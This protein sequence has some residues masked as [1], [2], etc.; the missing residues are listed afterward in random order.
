M[1]V[2]VILDV[3]VDV[4]TYVFLHG[5]L[6]LFLHV[7]VYM[8]GNVSIHMLLN[9]LRGVIAHLLMEVFAYG[10]ISYVFIYVSPRISSLAVPRA[11]CGPSCGVNII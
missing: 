9:A 11:P 1:F 6:N 3:V 10:F 4:L 8:L 7:V 2:H 5:C